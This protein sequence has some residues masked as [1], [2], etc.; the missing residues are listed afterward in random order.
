MQHDEYR[1]GEYVIST[2]R[3]RLDLST[4]HVYLS[5]GSYWA[6]GRTKEA[7]A[8]SIE[9]SLCF[10]VYAADGSQAGFARV[11]TDEATFA[12]LCDVFILEAHRGK[13]L[14]KWLVETV[15]A[16]PSLR[17]MPRT[18]LATRD[19]HNLYGRYGGFERLPNPDRWMVRVSANPGLHEPTAGAA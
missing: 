5:L 12:W 4:I 18:L 16:H 2:D 15:V 8:T 13:G 10:G 11:L 19:A 7:V 3:A 14:G 6:L 17:G 1:K 9:H